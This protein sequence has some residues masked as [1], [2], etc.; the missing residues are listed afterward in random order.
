M[1]YGVAGC[2]CLLLDT[3]IGVC[4]CLRLSD[5]CGQ[6]LVDSVLGVAVL[7]M[8]FVLGDTEV[9]IGSI[10]NWTNVSIY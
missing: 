6:Q 7:L 2:L 10:Y 9:I 3:F 8:L 5:T 1:F 4:V